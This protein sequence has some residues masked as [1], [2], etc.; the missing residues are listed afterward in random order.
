MKAKNRILLWAMFLGVLHSFVY[1]DIFTRIFKQGERTAEN[2]TE[3]TG[4]LKAV[5]DLREAWG[6]D[7]EYAHQIINY[8]QVAGKDPNTALQE[9]LMY[10]Q[11]EG[12]SFEQALK[13]KSWGIYL[14]QTWG[15][16]EKNAG[17]LLNYARATRQEPNVAL[18]EIRM[19]AQQEDISFEQ[20]LREKLKKSKVQEKL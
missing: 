3:E 15:I 13:Q 7:E 20:A 8:A 2:I 4:V 10:T 17:P 9:I 5:K 6:I 14:Q 19:Y 1:A 11:Q 12:T 16:D 18:Q